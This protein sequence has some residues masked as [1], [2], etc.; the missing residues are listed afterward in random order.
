MKMPSVA[1]SPRTKVISLVLLSLLVNSACTFNVTR[2]TDGPLTQYLSE[3]VP[4][5]NKPIARS[6]SLEKIE[7]QTASNMKAMITSDLLA[8]EIYLLPEDIGREVKSIL[9]LDEAYS[10]KTTRAALNVIAKNK[11]SVRQIGGQSATVS[12]ATT[13]ASSNQYIKRQESYAA[14]AYKKG[15]YLAGDIHNSAAI[16]AIQGRRAAEVTMATADLL[17]SVIGAAAAAGEAM[18]KNDFIKLRNWIEFQSGAIGTDAP[19]GSHLSVY[20]LRFFDAESFQY[21]SRYRVA[22]YLALTKTDGTVTEALEGSDVLNCEGECNLFQPK[23]GSKF[24]DMTTLSTDVQQQLGSAEGIQA[25]M[26]NGFDPVSGF[27]D[28]I[29]LRQGLQKLSNAVE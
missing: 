9:E 24:L 6:L 13:S 1:V 23:P 8:R 10:A 26:D 5:L 21:D 16:S 19:E 27:F 14:A 11:A 17:F 12:T 15:D 22:V 3:P 28:Y 29:L 4:K 7:Y 20:L 18:V 25:L 2:Y